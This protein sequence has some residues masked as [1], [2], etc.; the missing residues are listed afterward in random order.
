MIKT[1]L[2]IPKDIE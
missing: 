2:R 1:N